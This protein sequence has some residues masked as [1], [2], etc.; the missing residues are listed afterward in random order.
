[1]RFKVFFE[2]VVCGMSHMIC[3]GMSHGMSRDMSH[4]SK[5]CRLLRSEMIDVCFA[6]AS[7][8]QDFNRVY[9]R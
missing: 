2:D 1:M 5:L 7:D 4:M 8:L 3:H 6:Q 9:Q